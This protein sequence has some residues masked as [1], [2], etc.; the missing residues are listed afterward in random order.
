MFLRFLRGKEHVLHLVCAHDVQQRTL[1]K[2]TKE[3]VALLGDVKGRAERSVCAEL[4][5]RSLF[6]H[7]WVNKHSHIAGAESLPALVA[8]AEAII[9]SLH[10]DD[11]VMERLGTSKEAIEARP[12]SP[13][14]WVEEAI[15]LV[16][17]DHGLT[18]RVLPE[19]LDLHKSLASTAQAHLTLTMHNIARTSWLAASLLHCSPGV[20]QESANALLEQLLGTAPARRTQ[21]ETA[22]ANNDTYMANLQEFARADPPCKLWQRQGAFKPLFRFLALRFR[23]APDQVLD[24]EGTHARWQWLCAGKRNLS[25]VSMNAGLKLTR[26]L[27]RHGGELPAAEALAPLLA[28]ER[29]HLNRVREQIDREDEIAPGWRHKAVYMDRFNLQAADMDLLRD[30]SDA[31]LELVSFRTSYQTSFS[32]YL[33]DTLQSQAFIQVPG[34]S[35]DLW[36]YVLDTK[37]LAGREPR[38]ALDAQARPLVVSFFERDPSADALS[39]VVR[40]VNR[41]ADGLQTKAITVAELLVH[42]GYPA[43]PDPN[44]NASDKELILEKAFLELQTLVFDSHVVTDHGSIHVYQ[45]DNP[46]DSEDAF[47]DSM[48]LAEHTKFALARLLERRHGWDKLTTWKK[49]KPQILALEAAP[50]AAPGK[51]PGAAPAKARGAAP[52]AARGRAKGRARAAAPGRGRGAAPAAA[53]GDAR[54]AAGRGRGRGRKG[55]R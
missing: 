18:Q 55:G 54:G 52:A 36:V 47:M 48:P 23:L 4:L 26:F 21:F 16:Y 5:H 19:V 43:P 6:L 13:S 14:S 7:L 12:W 42:L 9:Q 1:T 34:V 46:R 37:T 33:R 53:L 51:A 41:E 45:L 32:V 25:L 2:R 10:L 40:R 31:P 15:W 27:E 28:D 24:V 50:G 8:R 17:E 20:A 22:L 29:S 3:A 11:Q 38:D 44:M 35:P 39:L 30:E 49:T